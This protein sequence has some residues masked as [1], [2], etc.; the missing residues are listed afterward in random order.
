MFIKLLRSTFFIVGTA[1]GAG[2]LA[3]PIATATSGFWGSLIALLITWVFMTLSA[4]N[5][6]KAR[7]CFK[8]D[9]DLATMSNKMLG[10]AG[11]ILIEVCYLALLFSLVSL[12]IM[13][14][15]AW[16]K[17]LLSLIDINLSTF[18]AQ[19]LFTS[20]IAVLIYSGIAKLSFVNKIV[21]IA[22]LLFLTLIIAFS[23]PKVMS[24]NLAPYSF[25]ELPSTLP[26]LI[27]T[28]GFSIVIPSLATYALNNQKLLNRALIM[29]SSIILIVYLGWELIAFGVIGTQPGLTELAG[30]KNQGTEVVHA[31]SLIVNEP[32]FNK[33]GFAFMVTAVLSSI[34][35]VG[36]CLFSYLKDTLPIRKPNLNSYSAILIGFVSPLIILA[37]FPAS[38]TALLGF[39][40]IFVA[41][42]LGI[43]PTLMVL[44]GHYRKQVGNLSASQRFISYTLLLFF[45]ATIVIEIK[46]LIV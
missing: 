9:V 19:T 23:F 5:M 29:G 22:M 36:Y 13:V 12:Y 39:S 40:G 30:K 20:F 38:V 46:N 25:Q 44:S 8:D 16:T 21:T 7:L 41:V 34:F 42:I 28:F 35:G 32:L 37:L 6:L 33:I 31:L 14:G 26:M 11:K 1:I 18:L 17:D 2:V 4:K 24:V 45:S 10:R 27:T 3:L 15:A 43:V